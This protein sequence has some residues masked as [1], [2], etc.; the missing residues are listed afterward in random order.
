MTLTLCLLAAI[1][2]FVDDLCFAKNLDPDEA[3]HNVGPHLRYELFDI[4][5]III[6]YINKKLNG[7]NLY[8]TTFEG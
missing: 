8:F 7:N 4:Q 2:K 5:I 3:P 6:Y 1:L